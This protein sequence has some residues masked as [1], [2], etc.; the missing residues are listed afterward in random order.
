[1][2]NVGKWIGT[3]VGMNLVLMAAAY[4]ETVRVAEF[5]ETNEAVLFTRASNPGI[6]FFAPKTETEVN[7]DLSSPL[8][9]CTVVLKRKRVDAEHL[10]A[11]HP[12]WAHLRLRNYVWAADEE[13]AVTIAESDSPAVKTAKPR[14]SPWIRAKGIT[15]N[16]PD[17]AVC[18]FNFTPRGTDVDIREVV[19][20][21]TTQAHEGRLIR[22]PLKLTLERN[23][24][25]G[26][27]VKE[28]LAPLAS[29][30]V[31]P[32]EAAF[33]LGL[34][35]GRAESS[36]LRLKDASVAER[37]AYFRGA[38]E[39]FFEQSGAALVFRPSAQSDEVGI[40]SVR[41]FTF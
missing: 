39:A 8:R 23:H 13:C 41:E 26:K 7:C 20:E 19:T 33:L 16:A 31:D 9:S 24:S 29:A 17:A 32:A 5:L 25:V 15:P 37:L 18:S 6:A 4:A 2:K 38:L 3:L 35:S 28:Q 34:A 27:E 12:E 36:N 10:A 22:S 14:L 30:P 1:M 21:L 40:K 11:E